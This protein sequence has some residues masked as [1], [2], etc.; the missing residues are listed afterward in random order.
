MSPVCI[1]FT[2]YSRLSI[3][4]YVSQPLLPF[5]SRRHGHFPVVVVS[6]SVMAP[7]FQIVFIFRYKIQ[8]KGGKRAHSIRDRTLDD[9]TS[10]TGDKGFRHRDTV[11]RLP[12]GIPSR[13]RPRGACSCE[14]PERGPRAIG[15]THSSTRVVSLERGS[16][17][18]VL[19]R[20]MSTGSDL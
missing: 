3:L 17:Q 13:P 14:D 6:T 8:C 10:G 16:K 12:L 4:F 18:T 7:G 5:V 2:L 15:S 9:R 19:P 1:I 20:R 11:I